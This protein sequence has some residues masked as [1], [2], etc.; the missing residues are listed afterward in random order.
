MAKNI[1]PQRAA[2]KLAEAGIT[3]L[4][5]YKA[6]AAGKGSKWLGAAQRAE[7][8]FKTGMQ[9]FL[10][11]GSLAARMSAAGPSAY[12]EG[13]RLKGDNYSTGMAAGVAKFLRNVTPF[14]GLWGAALPTARGSKGSPA[15]ITRMSENVKRFQD[16][17]K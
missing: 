9:A 7:A 8:N 17:K 10:T 3:K 2:E 13:V 6:G 11:K 12:D 5:D 14:T 16:A 1:T 4:A 15:N